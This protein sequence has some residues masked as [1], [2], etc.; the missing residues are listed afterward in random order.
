MLP[1][2]S[3]A[4]YT[5][6]QQIAALT[7][8]TVGKLWQR[9]GNDFDA[10]WREL[11][12]QMLRTLTAG[13]LATAAQSAGYVQA[14]LNETGD[15][16]GDPI[17]QL[18]PSAFAGTASDGRDLSTLLDFAPITAKHAVGQG[19]SV[20][21]AL[22]EANR[23]LTLAT[24]TQLAD[25]R[26][27]FVAADIGRRPKLG[28]YVRMLNPP[29]CYRCAILAGK[30][31][32]WNTGFQRHPRCDC[33]HVPASENMAKNLTTDP[34]TYFKSLSA[35]DQV[36]V[37]GK[38]EARAINDGADIYRVANIRNRGLSVAG[39]RQAIK[40]GTPT[41]VTVDQIYRTAGTRTN[42]IRLMRDHG[43]ITGEQVA[44]GN[45]LGQR[46]GFGTLGKGGKARAASD[47]VTRARTTGVRDPLNRYTMT[48]AERRLY[49]AK[50]RLD[51]AEKQGIWLRSIGANSADKYNRPT[52]VTP[53]QLATLRKNY[54]NE[55]DKL[56]GNPRRGIAPAPKSVQTLAGLLGIRV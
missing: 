19:Q 14:V 12:P 37:F 8:S 42:A 38:S 1:E 33:V 43:Y 6:Q 17:G 41:R 20:P 27:E 23:W 25:T 51:A 13:Q 28:G 56:R 21:D 53:S 45:I 29:S 3:V 44:G 7:T 10:S 24:L 40:Y 34:Y 5:Q 15:D 39:S 11:R 54:A 18:N 4:F 26:R 9:M 48:A 52:P 30:F 49:D 46:E 32:R 55:L 31:Y 36:K 47:A 50:L 22:A 2:A 35:P 16:G